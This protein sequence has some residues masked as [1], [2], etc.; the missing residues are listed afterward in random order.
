M[1]ETGTE[2]IVWQIAGLSADGYI[3]IIATDNDG[4]ILAEGGK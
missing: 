4:V 3:K 1:A 2:K